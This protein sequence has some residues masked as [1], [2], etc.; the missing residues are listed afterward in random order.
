MSEEVIVRFALSR[1][2]AALFSLC[3]AAA[4]AH[5]QSKPVAANK[6]AAASASARSSTST[7]ADVAEDAR[8]YSRAM[9]L[10]SAILKASAWAELGEDRCSVGKL[11]AFTRD[12][13]AEGRKRVEED[14]A[15]LERIVI[16]RGVE[17][18]IDTPAGRSLVS[19]IVGWEAGIARPHWD[20]L[21]GQAPEAIGAGLTGSFL[22]RETGKCESYVEIDTVYA[23]VPQLTRFVPP[24]AR[25]VVLHT[26]M[27]DSGVS[28]MRDEFYASHSKDQDAIL[29]YAKVNPVVLWRDLAVVAVNRPAERG[30]VMHLPKG[31]GGAS[32]I[33]RRVGAEWRLLAIVRTW[34]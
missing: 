5:A 9:T 32:Y 2:A 25:G 17:E 24:A 11:R 16:A 28:R 3:A 30:G 31:A 14:I 22:N 29:T 21:S 19:T 7:A 15:S 6:P 18:P 33:F 27:A 4:V 13:S 20:V 34:G 10:R 1:T 12:T 26:Y 8:Y 23:V